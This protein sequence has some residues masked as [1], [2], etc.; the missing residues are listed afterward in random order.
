MVTIYP[1]VQPT[2]GGRPDAAAHRTGQGCTPALTALILL[3][4][5]IAPG[6]VSAGD[7]P[8]AVVQGKTPSAPARHPLPAHMAVAG[9]FQTGAKTP[10]AAPRIADRPQWTTSHV[11][12]SP[13]PPSPYTVRRA[14]PRLT[15]K[16]PVHLILGPHRQRLFLTERKGRIVSFP[17]RQDADEVALFLQL[18]DDTY[19][20]T[21]HPRFDAHRYVYVFTNT[22]P[23]RQP[24]AIAHNRILRFQVADS[25]PPRAIP[26]TR[27]V[28][29]EYKSD[30]HNGG[31]LAFGPDGYLYITSGDGTGDSDG[32]NTGQNIHDLPSGMIRI[33]VDHPGAGRNY[34]IPKDNPFLEFDG[35]R[36]ELWAYGFRNPWRL[37]FG[38]RTGTLY[39][40]DVGQDL[41]E[42]IERVERGGNYGWSV[43]EGSHPFHSLKQR[44]PTPIRPPLIEHPHTEA[45][46]IIGGLVYYGRQLPRLEG[47]YI[48]GDYETGK[49]WGLRHDG[50]HVTWH[51]ELAD[52]SLKLVAFAVG[53][54]R[55]LYLVAHLSGEIDQLVPA[56][57]EQHRQAFPVR[58]RDTGLFTSLQPLIPAPGLIPYTVNAPQWSDGAVAQRYIGLPGA[59]RITFSPSAAW[60]FPEGTVLVKTLTLPATPGAHGTARHLET[61]ILTLQSGQWHGYTYVWNDEQTAAELAPAEGG[62]RTF[63]VDDP[64][65][66][67]GKRR[68][69]WHLVS[70]SECMVCH[71]RAAGFVLGPR[72]A[73]MN[74]DDFQPAARPR[75]P[76]NSSHTRARA[77][78]ASYDVRRDTPQSDNQLRRLD[79][80]KVFTKPLSQPPE[81]LPRLANPY[82]EDANLTDRAR[83]Y[84]QANCAHCHVVAGGGNAKITLSVETPLEKMELVGG[85]P[86]HADFG[87]PGAML[88]APGDPDRSILYQRISRRG[89]GQMPPLGTRQV[90][91]RAVRLIRQWI[92]QIEIPASARDNVDRAIAAT[93]GASG[94]LARWHVAGPLPRP[95][96]RDRLAELSTAAQKEKATDNGK[97]P[98]QWHRSIGSGRECRVGLAMPGD[99][100]PKPVWVAR[101]DVVI[102][103]ACGVQLLAA[104]NTQLD[105]WVNGRRLGTFD[106][107]QQQAAVSHGFDATLHEGRNRLLLEVVASSVKAPFFHVNF[108]RKS[109]NPRH[110]QLTRAAL[111]RSG[112]PARGRTLFLAADKTQCVK[113]HRVGAEGGRVGPDLT[114]VGERL[115]K[116]RI[117]ESILEPN[118]TV[119]PQYRTMTVQLEDGRTLKGVLHEESNDTI[120]LANDQGQLVV[121]SKSN[122]AVEHFQPVSLMPEGLEKPLSNDE[123]V[124][125]VT[126]LEN[127]TTPPQ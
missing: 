12:G 77:V 70:R 101:T 62:D 40:G 31:D 2:G 116:T 120:T 99:I 39:V 61:Q 102:D 65:A 42:M 66:L 22:A 5:A 7:V 44:G 69:T 89:N 92:E 60:Q 45:R 113:C 63:S 80:W 110:E 111:D 15:F 18:D 49:I 121:V 103:R 32:W 90:D 4:V 76:R 79:H 8:A 19:A 43:M 84:L 3:G 52:T 97:Q 108:R 37:S 21:F 53:A 100:R 23:H 9:R 25:D 20:I 33:D 68:R 17:D 115:S 56:P 96:E 58:L 85:R 59:G 106:A 51:A 86:L 105:V 27:Q 47:A 46:S 6:T 67:Q 54:D 34:G 48:Y 114:G 82:D 87:I 112:D 107:D 50:Q 75:P 16:E 74:R 81:K 38:E 83:A 14:F 125:L 13:E 71:S 122:I 73:Q 72:T 64:A 117:I 91:Q 10:V 98:L 24:G 95:L 26:A 109:S 1:D 123:F 118:R 119:A 94:V 124:D 55:Q 57:A 88:I 93:Q 36:P 127:L 104:S 11:I 41:W 35:A 29:L 30:G 78:R 126:F 28:V